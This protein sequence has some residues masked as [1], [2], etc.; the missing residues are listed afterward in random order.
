MR[1]A[2]VTFADNKYANSLKRIESEAR[3]FNCFTD[4]F[5]FHEKDLDDEFVSE[6]KPWLYRRGFGYWR[7][8]PY[9]VKKVIDQIEYGDV[10]VWADAGC[11]LNS[12][13][14][15]TLL[16]HI[17]QARLSEGGLVVFEQIQ[18]EKNWSKRDLLNYLHATE[19]IENTGQLWAGSWIAVKNQASTKMIDQWYDIC[20]NH[21]DLVSD[22][23]SK[24]PNYPTF[25]EHRWDQSVFSVLVK[26][27]D[28]IVKLPYESH[29][30]CPIIG[31]RFKEKKQIGKII[32]KMII[33]WRF[34]LGCYLKYIRGFYFYNR[35]T[36]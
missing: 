35:I 14:E 26:K 30:E 20:R 12:E 4:F 27:I 18:I 16:S 28:G 34:V 36:W 2:F 15:N 29:N 21:F 5:V 7:W 13:A 32:S 25:V 1:I 19:E 17:D 6:L 24:T 8:K 10:I 22:K 11:I 23:K 3:R 33:P 31:A 9:F